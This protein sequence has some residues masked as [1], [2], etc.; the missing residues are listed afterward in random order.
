MKEIFYIWILSTVPME[1]Q[2]P[3]VGYNSYKQCYQQLQNY[4]LS[5]SRHVE[6]QGIYTYKIWGDCVSITPPKE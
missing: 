6:N 5:M 1:V 4:V 2:L 3:E